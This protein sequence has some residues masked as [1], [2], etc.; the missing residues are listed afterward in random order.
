MNVVAFILA[1]VAFACFL[2]EAL[3]S[4]SLVAAGLAVLTSAWVAELTWTTVHKVSF[5]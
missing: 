3:R 2:A 4:R 5:S 1:V